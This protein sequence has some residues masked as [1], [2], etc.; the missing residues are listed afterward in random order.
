MPLGYPRVE[1]AES[2]RTAKGATVWHVLRD[3]STDTLMRVV[4]GLEAR[5][6]DGHASGDDIDT[7]VQAQ[8][9]I[10][11]RTARAAD[12]APPGPDGGRR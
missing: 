3:L 7:Y 1:A 8:W 5:I 6:I 2:P 9:E 4:A 12:D 11:N 10:A